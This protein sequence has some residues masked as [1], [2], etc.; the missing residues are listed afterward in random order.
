MEG[1]SFAVRS[2]IEVLESLDCPMD[3]IIASGGAA[4]SDVW[5]QIQADIYGREL[6]LTETCEQT[7]TGAAIVAG[8]GC[9]LYQNIEQGCEQMVSMKKSI[10]RPDRHRHQIYSEFYHKAYKKIYEKNKDIFENLYDLK[11]E[12]AVKTV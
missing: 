4:K 6:H 7:V 5:L 9:G 8:V 12:S 3:T 1:V 2:N 11:D 10:V